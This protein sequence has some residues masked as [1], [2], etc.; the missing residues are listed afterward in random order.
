MSEQDG[1]QSSTKQ[2]R[3]RKTS[4]VQYQN[5]KQ[6]LAA[7]HPTNADKEAWKAKQDQFWRTEPEIDVDRQKYL[8]E[9]QNIKPDIEQ[10]IYSF[11]DIKLSRADIEWLLATHESGGKIGPVD[12]SDESQRE[13]Q[14]LDL[15][16][17]NLRRLNLSGL[18][19]A[20]I[21]AGSRYWSYATED[22][23]EAAQGHLEGASLFNAH[24]EGAF[25]AYAHLEHADLSSAS[26]QRASFRSAHLERAW[27]S[28]A[29][30]ESANLRFAHLEGAYLGNA[31][32]ESA[33][34]CNAFFDQ[35]T[36]LN[37]IVLGNRKSGIAS[38]VDIH[39][40]DV[41]LAVVKW[42][43]VDMLGEEYKAQQKMNWDGKVKNR[44]ARV[45]EYERAVRA[46]RQLATALQAQGLNEEAARFAYR[47]QRLQCIVLRRQK[48][49]GQYLFSR[50]LDF[51]AGYGYK[52]GRS[53]LWYLG[54]IA[55]FAVAYHLY[56]GL[57]LYPPDTFVYSLTSFHGRGFFPGFS[58][59]PSLHDPLIMLAAL[60][61]VIGLF[62][63][64]SFIATFT[65]RF[66]GK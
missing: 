64:I 29:H 48:K 23:H 20:R 6:A 49:I 61:A 44:D 52:P 42:S 56:G 18:P 15:R 40:G 14:G 19:L 3:N 45:E 22:Q 65:Q 1:V 9:R 57:S 8:A 25:L 55:L 39:W 59:K 36:Q 53:V 33:L 63:E 27:L 66:F 43:Q 58:A 47:A 37:T 24:L 26:L 13:R 17:A 41:N 60:E 46:N 35:A 28:E 10:G 32:L 34:L 2:H 30:L 16:G 38:L 7:K 11:K 50:F 62:I 54:I 21:Y 12:W 31:Y 5:S 51:L 4:S